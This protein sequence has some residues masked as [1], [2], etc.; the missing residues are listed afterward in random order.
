MRRAMIA[1]TRYA[2]CHATR[3]VACAIRAHRRAQRTNTYKHDRRIDMKNA[4]ERRRERIEQR[5]AFI[6]DMNQS[7][8]DDII[9][10]IDTI[11]NVDESFFDI[12]IDVRVDIDEYDDD[13]RLSFDKSCVTI[14]RLNAQQCDNERF[15][16]IIHDIE[17][18]LNDDAYQTYTRR[19]DENTFAIIVYNA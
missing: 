16:E 14:R 1:T 17:R 13:K 4:I 2:T 18:V 12:D 9:D 7:R 19:D 8:I 6:R 11:E 3:R 5:N 10:V 15:D